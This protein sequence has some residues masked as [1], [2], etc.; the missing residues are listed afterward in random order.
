M[1]SLRSRPCLSCSSMAHIHSSY[2]AVS[3]RNQSN[4]HDLDGLRRFVCT[5]PKTLK[6]LEWMYLCSI[7]HLKPGMQWVAAYWGPLYLCTLPSLVTKLFYCC[8]LVFLYL[9]E[10]VPFKQAQNAQKLCM[11]YDYRL[12]L[13]S[14]FTYLFNLFNLFSS[15]KKY[16]VSFIG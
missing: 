16:H 7:A 6:L 13:Y 15:Q 11:L 8:N 14:L 3:T 12:Q 5:H 9:P 4:C 1:A 10:E 2:P